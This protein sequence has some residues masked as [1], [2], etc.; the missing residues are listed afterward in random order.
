MTYVHNPL[1]KVMPLLMDL[2]SLNLFKK[3]LDLDGHFNK[4]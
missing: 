2:P 1:T 3:T 4:F